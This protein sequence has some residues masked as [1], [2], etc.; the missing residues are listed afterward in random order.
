M[1]EKMKKKE[2]MNG[3]VVVLFLCFI[4]DWENV[5]KRERERERRECVWG[6]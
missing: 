3:V 2:R 5:Q 4:D 6:D 1:G